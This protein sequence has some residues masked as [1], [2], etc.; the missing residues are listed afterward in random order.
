MVRIVDL[1]AAFARLVK[2]EGRSHPKR[3]VAPR[4]KIIVAFP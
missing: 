3:E 2:L 1:D 4:S